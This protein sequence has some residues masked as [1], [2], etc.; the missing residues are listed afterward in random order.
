MSAKQ[1]LRPWVMLL[2]AGTVTGALGQPRCNTL[3][4]SERDV[5]RATGACRD[6]PIFDVSPKGEPAPIFIPVPSVVGLR[7][8]DAR[9]QLSSFTVQRSQR[10]SAE[11]GG[12]VLEQQP[13]PPTRLEI[14][15]T[16]RLVLSDGTLRTAPR[17]AASNI[18]GAPRAAGPDAQ[19]QGSVATDDARTGTMIEQKPVERP[20]HTP[21]PSRAP[22]ARAEVERLRVPN[23]IGMSIENARARLGRFKVERT[24]RA[25]SAPIGRVIQQVPKAQA[26][27]TAGSAIALVVSSGPVTE[28]FELPNVIGRSYADA[29][30]AMAE[31]KID[32]VEIAAAAQSGLVLAQN[33]APGTSVLPRSAVTLHVSDGSL[34]IPAAATPPVTST[35]EPAPLLTQR[36]QSAVTVTLPS[37]AALVLSAG[38]LLGLAFGALLMRHW[39][40]RRQYALSRQGPLSREP[41]IDV[42]PARIGFSPTDTDLDAAPASEVSEV[43]VAAHLEAG[44]TAIEFRAPSDADEAALEHEDHHE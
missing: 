13:A 36:D 37:D 41:T 18:E 24:D 40:L 42:E 38:V 29:S 39:L 44:E 35:P 1:L 8:D 16:V 27:A 23:V 7:F 43:R 17:A 14:G 10:A 3:P 21:A 19:S 26:R 25:D 20:I 28:T 4:P 31:F 5:A 2:L 11:P 22:A 32:R 6:V 33:P 9:A 34:A 15:G 30:R 12:T